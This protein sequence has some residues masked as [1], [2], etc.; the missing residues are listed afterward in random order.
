VPTILKLTLNNCEDKPVFVNAQ[1][2]IE[3][4]QIEH[5]SKGIYTRLNMAYEITTDVKETPD[6][7]MA[8]LKEAK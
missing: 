5:D 8:L 2:I 1:N 3:F 6:E 4:F 7:I